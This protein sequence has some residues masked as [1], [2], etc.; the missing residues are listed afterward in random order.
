VSNQELYFG[1]MSFDELSPGSQV[2]IG[3]WE[4]VNELY[5]GGFTQ[6]FHNS[7]RDRAKRMIQLLRSIDAD[8][9]AAML[10]EA[11]ALIGPGTR[12]GDEDDSAAAVKSMPEEIRRRVHDLEH[13]FYD[14]LDSLHLLVFSY[15]SQHR[16][17]IDAPPDFWTEATS[18]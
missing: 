3:T 18:Q 9:A 17:Q 13:A 2:L 5:N 8:R 6:Y 15:L 4:L 10:E 7:S 12:W 11:T 1:L 16:D 14:E